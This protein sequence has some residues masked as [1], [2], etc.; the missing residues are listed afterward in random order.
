[1]HWECKSASLGQHAAQK[2][3]LEHIRQWEMIND[4]CNCTLPQLRHSN[5]QSR[6]CSHSSSLR[7]ARMPWG[8]PCSIKSQGRAFQQT[9]LRCSA[10]YP[11]RFALSFLAQLIALLYLAIRL[12]MLSLHGISGNK[13]RT[14]CPGTQCS[15]WHR[16]IDVTS[17][18]HYSP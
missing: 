5:L 3:R 14:Q 1:M 6:V 16:L 18:R 17:G 15:G 13:L 10:I 2:L 12:P 7:L 11:L 9:R 4:M 8:S